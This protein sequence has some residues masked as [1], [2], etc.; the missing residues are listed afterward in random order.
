MFVTS[1]LPNAASLARATTVETDACP[2]FPSR[3]ASQRGC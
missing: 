3:P 1:G 2:K